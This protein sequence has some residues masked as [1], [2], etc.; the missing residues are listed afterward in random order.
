LS[1]RM[2]RA[3]DERRC[4]EI[5]DAERNKVARLR[6]RCGRRGRGGEN[7]CSDDDTCAKV[8]NFRAS[9]L[10]RQRRELDDTLSFQTCRR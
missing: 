3:V 10:T 6:Q 1:C 7:E 5:T 4:F 2:Q 8:R 9:G